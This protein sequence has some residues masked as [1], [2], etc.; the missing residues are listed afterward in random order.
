MI[1]GRRSAHLLRSLVHDLMT[2]AISSRTP[3]LGEHPASAASL[4]SWNE[5]PAKQSI[6]NFVRRVT[7]AGDPHFVK[8]DER[9]AVFDNDGTLWSEMPTYFQLAFVF[10][11]LKALAPQHPEWKDNPLCTAVLQGDKK[12]VAA[13]GLRRLLELATI[14]LRG[15]RVAHLLLEEY[16]RRDACPRIKQLLSTTT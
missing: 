13:S 8:P 12:T 7:T 16:D 1:A 14:T 5:G 10:D 4:P 11:R 6:I 9:I 3:G 15:Q 2:A